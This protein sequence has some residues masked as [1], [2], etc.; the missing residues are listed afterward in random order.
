MDLGAPEDGLQGQ[1]AVA[2]GAVWPR[3]ASEVDAS[4]AVAVAVVS[5]AAASVADVHWKEGRR[6]GQCWRYEYVLL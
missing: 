3:A 5:A 1:K 2:V 4:A 6:E